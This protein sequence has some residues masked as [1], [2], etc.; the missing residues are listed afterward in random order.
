MR[1]VTTGINDVILIY[2]KI[3]KDTRG[4]FVESYNNNTLLREGVKLPVFVQDNFS[5]SVSKHTA[6][7][8]HFQKPPK[9]QAK[10]V[11][12][13][14]GSILDIA[15]DIRKSSSTYGKAVQQIITDKHAEQLFIPEGFLHGFITLEPYTK[16]FY[17]CS[18]YYDSTCDMSVS[19][20]GL[21]TL[22]LQSIL[23]DKDKS[24]INFT[25]FESPF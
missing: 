19:F 22:P 1:I 16:V 15:I 4:A 8:L 18:D 13:M 14:K 2:P 11:T 6:R 24:A 3:H 12:C 7:G 20:N 25:D 17:K 23:S 10:L 5:V 9:A 21:I